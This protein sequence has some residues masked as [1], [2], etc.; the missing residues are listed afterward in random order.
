MDNLDIDQL[1]A[2]Q[3][4]M[5]ASWIIADQS[6]AN[7]LADALMDK[8]VQIHARILELEGIEIR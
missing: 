2:A 3:T 8:I 7:G 4:R 6:K 1:R 5:V